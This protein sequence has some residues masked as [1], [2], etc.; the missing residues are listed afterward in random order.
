[1]RS[2]LIPSPPPQLLK[3][4]ADPEWAQ[5]INEGSIDIKK[6]VIIMIPR[7]TQNTP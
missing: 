4:I 2:G 5:L 3:S 7:H 1:M 6:Y